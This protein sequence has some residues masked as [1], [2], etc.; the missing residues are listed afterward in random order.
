MNSY[1]KIKIKKFA[2]V[3]IL[4]LILLVLPFLSG[5]RVNE[6]DFELSN[7]IGK[8]IKNFEKKTKVDL[9]EESNGVYNIEGSLQV[10]APKG[11]IESI[12]ILE[13]SEA[14]KLFGVGIGIDKSQAELKLIEVYDTEKNR[15]IDTDKNSI[16]HTYRDNKSELYISFDIDTELVTEVSYYYLEIDEDSSQDNAEKEN[17]GELIALVGDSRIYYNEA[18]VYLKSAQENYEA[19]YGKGIWEVDIFGDG[20]SFGE[21]IKDEVIKQITQL[22]VICG[23]A[24]ELGITLTEEEK[25][26]AVTHA[27]EHFAGLSDA[28]IDRFMVT[29][30]LLEQVYAD[31]ILAEK[32]FETIT[33]DVDTNVSELSSKQITIKHILIYGTEINDE[34]N[35]KPL[36][37]EQREKALEKTN[38]LLEKARGGEDF[39]ALAE[40]N[41]EDE[42]IEYTFGRGQ[43][44]EDFSKVFEQA[45]F[46]LKTGEISSI[47]TTDYGWHIIYCVSDNN[48]DATTKVKEAI[49]EERRTRLFADYYSQ[50]SL[51]YEVVINSDAWDKILLNK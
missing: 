15:N 32:V 34:G 25:A 9:K 27:A 33:I 42:V 28:D 6:G 35:R 51:E 5:C 17:A 22:K 37:L 18:M 14:Y 36:S 49:I 43:G 46:N 26:D 20:K 8:T 1:Y 2:V 29:K 47:I 3:N 4:L 39:N 19:D 44:P 12:T 10:I 23:K 24:A 48:V 50:W 21:Y 30:G 38:T 11:N 40:S 13:G 45:A 41:S 16:T 7:Y 31:N